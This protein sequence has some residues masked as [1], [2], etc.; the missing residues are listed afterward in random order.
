M[1]HDD[2]NVNEKINYQE[3]GSPRKSADDVY[4]RNRCIEEI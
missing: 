1:K 2:K 4:P 3:K